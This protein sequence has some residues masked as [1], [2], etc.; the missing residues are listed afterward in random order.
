MQAFA[1]PFGGPPHVSDG[2]DYW[3]ALSSVA[4]LWKMEDQTNWV[5]VPDL[6]K[7]VGRW[8]LKFGG[9]Y[10]NSLANFTDNAFPFSVRTS[11]NFTTRAL[12]LR[13]IRDAG[14]RR[15]S[16]G[17][18]SVERTKAATA[19]SDACGADVNLAPPNNLSAA[20]RV[21]PILPCDFAITAHPATRLWCQTQIRRLN[22]VWSN[23]TSGVEQEKKRNIGLPAGAQYVRRF[24]LRLQAPGHQ[25]PLP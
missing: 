24:D 22:L 12:L 14:R 9:E 8:T 13:P 19:V 18:T 16:G 3:S 25:R 10:R 6:T 23:H 11:P 1:V 20:L 5:F 4:F 21:I 17:S 2:I 15:T 7:T